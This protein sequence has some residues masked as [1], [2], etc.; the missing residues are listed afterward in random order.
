L[1]AETLERDSASG[2]PI[3]GL[4]DT[5]L[6]QAVSTTA[7]VDGSAVQL[8]SVLSVWLHSG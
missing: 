5:G 3:R 6:D 7:V 1:Q 4:A 2:A 8:T